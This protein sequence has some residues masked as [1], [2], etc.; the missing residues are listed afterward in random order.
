MGFGIFSGGE[1]RSSGGHPGEG[2]ADPRAKN[3]EPL[4][5]LAM[6]DMTGRWH[7]A[8]LSGPPFAGLRTPSLPSSPRRRG[9]TCAVFAGGPAVPW[10]APSFGR[11]ARWIPAF[12][13]MTAGVG[14]G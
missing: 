2:K 11:K 4:G 9:S 8:P 13:G 5:P 3:A 1:A 10:Q 12:A 14:R 7:A 6:A